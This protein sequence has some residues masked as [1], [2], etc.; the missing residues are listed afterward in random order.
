MNGKTSDIDFCREYKVA[1]VLRA[2][3]GIALGLGGLGEMI[4]FSS[5]V[6]DGDRELRRLGAEVRCK[7]KVFGRVD[8]E[9]W[10]VKGGVRFDWAGFRRNLDIDIEKM[11]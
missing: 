1:E 5:R 10:W 11:C 2:I 7:L 3:R 9:I 8:E 4:E 6:F